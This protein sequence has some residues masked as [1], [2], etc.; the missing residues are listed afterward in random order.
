MYS[1]S[2]LPFILFLPDSKSLSKSSICNLYSLLAPTTVSLSKS[3]SFKI[4]F[5]FSESVSFASTYCFA[6]VI[7][8]SKSLT[9]LFEFSVTNCSFS[10]IASSISLSVRY[11]AIFSII[12]VFSLRLLK[13]INSKSYLPSLSNFP[14]LSKK[15]LSL[16]EPL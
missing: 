9:F 7:S 1:S 12:S 3:S 14:Y 2:F 16:D 11:E 5:F 4:S 6:S 13:E 15:D 10:S 8:A